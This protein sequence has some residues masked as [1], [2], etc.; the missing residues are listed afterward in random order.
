MSDQRHLCPVCSKRTVELRPD[1]TANCQACGATFTVEQDDEDNKIPKYIRESRVWRHA[2]VLQ[3]TGNPYTKKSASWLIYQ[4]I[5]ENPGK[6]IPEVVTAVYDDLKS[7]NQLLLISDVITTCIIAG[8]MR[9]DGE[10]V[11]AI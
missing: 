7:S 4:F 6:T 2:K 8:L 10:K 5:D 1:N 3:K 9:K 11:Y